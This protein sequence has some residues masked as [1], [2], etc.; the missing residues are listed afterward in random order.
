[1]AIKHD[2]MENY[3]SQM[4]RHESLKLEIVKLGNKWQTL[5]DLSHFAI[6]HK[7]FSD[8]SND[9]PEIVAETITYWQYRDALIDWY[10]PSASRLGSIAL[11]GVMVH[12]LTHVLLSPME[13]NI[14]SNREELGELATENVARAFLNLKNNG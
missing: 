10:L 3:T 7:F 2:L 5:L 9:D 11:E 8:F 4:S 14:K 6:E 13:S 12:E 1:M